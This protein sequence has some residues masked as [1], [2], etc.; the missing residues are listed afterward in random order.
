MVRKHWGKPFQK[1]NPDRIKKF[2]WT[3]DSQLT[4][5][6]VI[7][8][9]DDY[10]VCYRE[11]GQVKYNVQKVEKRKRVYTDHNEIRYVRWARI[12]HRKTPSWKRIRYLE[13]T[14]KTEFI[15]RYIKEFPEYLV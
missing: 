1:I 7:D 12:A 11:Y 13:T 2:V 8:E 3:D 4:K 5:H 10:Y 9:T 6:I 15:D 14:K